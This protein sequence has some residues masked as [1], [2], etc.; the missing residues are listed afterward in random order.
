M[1]AS[2]DLP[3]AHPHGATLPCVVCGVLLPDPPWAFEVFPGAIVR[4]AVECPSCGVRYSG[5]LLRTADVD[6][7]L[8]VLNR[9]LACTACDQRVP[10]I[11]TEAHQI[12]PCPFH[13]SRV[14]A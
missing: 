3:R 8:D 7:W 4:D 12:V 10:V 14:A 13:G 9:G 6:I 1:R 11:Y 5:D 2:R